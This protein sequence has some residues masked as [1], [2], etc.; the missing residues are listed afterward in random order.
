MAIE[1]NN[2]ADL[3]KQVFGYVAPGYYPTYKPIEVK[4]G[5]ARSPIEM[6]QVFEEEKSFLG[7]ALIIPVTLNDWRLPN[8]PLIQITGSK[9]IAETKFDGQDGTFK[10]LYSLND[11]I[12]TIKGFAINDDDPDSFPEDI[13]R[14]LRSVC[15]VKNS[16]KI[17]NKLTNIFRIE[18]LSIK[19]FEFVEYEGSAGIQPYQITGSSDRE[20]DLELK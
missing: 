19:N 17:V 2:L 14:K 3:Y 11:Y 10:E 20:F 5:E 8:E 6:K 18:W 15:E 4:P 9:E 12:I 16:V 7:T 13:V 1:K